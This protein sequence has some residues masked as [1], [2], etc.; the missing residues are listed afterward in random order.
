MEAERTEQE[1]QRRQK[2]QAL[3]DAGIEP[4]QSRF[5]RSHSSAEA[6]ALFES[7]EKTAGAEA[8]TDPTSLAGRLVAS[9]VMGKA[10]FAHIQD[11]AG[12]I[13][14]HVKVDKLGED[15]YRRFTELDL[16]DIIGVT[17]SLFRTRRGEVTCEVD[18]F[19]LLAKALRPLPEKYHGLKDKEI[20]FRQRYLDLIANPEV[21]QL[22]LTRGRVL[23]ETRVFLGE[24]GFVEVETPVLQA[25]AGGATAKPFITHHNAM[26]RDLYLRIALELYLKRLIVGGFDRVFEIGRIFRNEGMDQWHNPEFTMLELYQAYTD[27]KGMLELTESL[28]AHLVLEVNG[29]P[30]FTYQGETIDAAPPFARIEMLEAASQAVDEDL[31]AADV[32][33]LREIVTDLKIEARA[34]LG[35]GGLVNE[36]F[37]QRVQNSL[38]Q[39]TFVTGHPVEISPL[40]RRRASDPRLSDRFELILAREEMANAFSE[41]NDP[42]DQR[43]RFEDQAR[44]RSAGEQETHPMDEDFLIALEH[45]FPPTGGMGLGIDRLVAILTDQPSIRDVI[46]FPHMRSQHAEP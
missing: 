21:M 46:L 13:Q 12:R 44:A 37:E 32:K 3:R 10:T 28:V 31:A 1:Q 9:R 35:W 24:R 38:V 39:P 34:N 22:F 17:G 29:A 27:W 19:T 45:G 36:I 20:R 23:D 43:A 25:M 2:M 40:A 26:K 7:L 18:S 11:H 33:K 8:R 41:L 4:Y 15:A 5:D 16:G 6:V 42:D 30:S 14:L